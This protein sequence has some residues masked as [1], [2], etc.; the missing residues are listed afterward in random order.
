MK[1]EIQFDF[2]YDYQLKIKAPFIDHSIF[3]YYFIMLP[4]IPIMFLYMCETVTGFFSL[5]H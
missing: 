2:P 3:F 1:S 4:P 5:F